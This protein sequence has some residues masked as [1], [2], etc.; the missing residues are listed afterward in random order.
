MGSPR[1]QSV[2]T[3]RLRSERQKM[4]VKSP[5]GRTFCLEDIRT[6]R[7]AINVVCEKENLPTDSPSQWRAEQCGKLVTSLDSPLHHTGTLYILP[8]NP[9]PG[10]KGGFGSLLRAIGAQIQKTTNHEA[11]RDLSGR[12]QRDVNNEQRA[13]EYVAKQAEREREER[14][15]KEAKLAKL[16][17]L[18]ERE[19]KHE[20][21]D[22]QYDKVRSETEENVHDAMEAA[23]NVAKEKKNT[24]DNKETDLKRKAEPEKK[25][26]PMK[27][28]WMG[29]GL[30]GLSDE[31]LSDSDEEAEEKTEKS[32]AV[33]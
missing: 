8:S 33:A 9:L 20:F 2:K 19:N 13:R 5:L 4:F 32:K 3:T 18:A 25:E 7:D 14:E 17:R 11:M 26:P 6:A 12:R 16:K 24:E 27:K 31:D 1:L 15:K 28:M 23:M 21:S 30:E 29:D 22:P 10:G